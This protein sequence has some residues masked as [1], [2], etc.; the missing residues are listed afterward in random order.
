LRAHAPAFRE[1]GARLAAV[2][3]GDR[4]YA[5]R[6]REETRLPFPLLVDDR[7]E[8]YAAA[9]LGSAPLLHA[10]RPDNV[11]ALVRA[12]RAGHQQ[13]PRGSHP[14]QLGG[15]FAFGPGDVDLFVHV[16]RTFGDTA[17]P[18]DVLAALRR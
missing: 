14:F 13:R 16:S 7:R 10:L 8:A 9:G 4:A 12:R 11:V 5:R 6:F 1:A 18:A 15:T 17:D 3:L 2:G